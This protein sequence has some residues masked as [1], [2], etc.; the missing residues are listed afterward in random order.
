M[1][2]KKRVNNIAKAI[3]AQGYTEEIIQDK[4]KEIQE[5]ASDE[6]EA[7]DMFFE[8]YVEVKQQRNFQ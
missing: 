3:K 7:Y 6:M 4:W 8:W 5:L 1:D 2:I